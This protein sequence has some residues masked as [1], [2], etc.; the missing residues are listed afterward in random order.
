MRENKKNLQFILSAGFISDEDGKIAK[1]V[2]NSNFNLK[3]DHR[4]EI[5]TDNLAVKSGSEVYICRAISSYAYHNH[6]CKGLEQCSSGIDVVTVQQAIT[7]G[8][9]ELV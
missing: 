6:F 4:T 3:I 2:N 7:K 1:L 5:S 9:R 8:H